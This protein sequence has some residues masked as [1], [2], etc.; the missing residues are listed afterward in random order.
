[1]FGL[2]LTSTVNS[3]QSEL[4][5]AQKLAC[6][7]RERFEEIVRAKDMALKAQLDLSEARLAQIKQKNDEIDIC[8]RRTQAQE[9]ELNSLKEQLVTVA[10]ERDEKARTCATLDAE[11]RLLRSR[12]YITNEY[13]ECLSAIFS[14]DRSPIFI[15]GPAGTGKST[16]I[17]TARSLFSR[18]HP[19]RALQV[20]APTGIAAENIGGRTIHSFFR[21]PPDD[22][23]KTGYRVDNPEDKNDIALIRKTDVLIVDEASMVSPILVDAIDD[24][25]RKLMGNPNKVFGGTKLVFIGDLGQLPPVHKNEIGPYVE[26]NF[27]TRYFFGAHSLDRAALRRR[28][29]RLTTV[30]RQSEKAFVD[31]LMQVRRGPGAVTQESAQ[32]LSSCFSPNPPPPHERTTLCATNAQA[33]ALNREGLEALPDQERR[34]AMKTQGR[35]TDRQKQDS[36]FPIELLLK[37]GA[38][39]MLL[40]NCLPVY[41]NGTIGTVV[42]M[43]DNIINVRLASG[44]V[45][46][47]TRKEI[48]LKRNSFD[49][50]GNVTQQTVGSIIQFPMKLA[51]GI[52]IHKGQGQTLDDVYVDLSRGF[53]TGQAYTALSRVRT[54][55]GLHLLCPFDNGQIIFDPSIPDWI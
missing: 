43:D 2:S 17:R 19:S 30:F 50:G 29:Y 52:T 55:A 26:K 7:D 44:K 37:Q 33:D 40:D 22:F 14:D 42:M 15:N 1:M 27:G 39:V 46:P 9:S 36:K 32:L 10:E 38:R 11:A 4:V 54:L 35:V 24:A 16:L 3:L 8:R 28:M 51:W 20:V 12:S 6:V 18:S 45:V 49:I 21:F 25:L 23:P 13:L 5:A 47:V 53:E 31:A 41:C 48:E 34:Y